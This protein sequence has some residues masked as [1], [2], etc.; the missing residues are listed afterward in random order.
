[1]R[2]GVADF[3]EAFAP[4]AIMLALGLVAMGAPRLVP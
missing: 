1:M 3:L 4:L 2:R